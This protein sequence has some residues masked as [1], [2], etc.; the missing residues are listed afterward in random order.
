MSVVSVFPDSFPGPEI[1]HK[2]T[3]FEYHLKI[4]N[5]ERCE[6]SADLDLTLSDLLIR[7][8]HIGKSD[9]PYQGNGI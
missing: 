1:I 9:I 7:T 5:F 2:N 3:N 8:D 6:K 4:P